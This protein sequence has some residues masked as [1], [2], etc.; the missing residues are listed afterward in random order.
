MSLNVFVSVNG[1]GEGVL[2][3]PD[4]AD[5]LADDLGVDE[6][7]DRC[8][9][10]RIRGKL[11]LIGEIEQIRVYFLFSFSFFITSLAL[12]GRCHFRQ[13]GLMWTRE[14]SWENTIIW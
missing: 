4:P 7:R 13:G 14:D 11:Q 10:G 1:E 12:S 9:R 2:D 6:R 8:G 5:D 3:G